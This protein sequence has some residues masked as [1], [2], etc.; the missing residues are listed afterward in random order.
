MYK[1]QLRV[2][3]SAIFLLLINLLTVHYIIPTRDQQQW[4][5]GLYKRST[6]NTHLSTDG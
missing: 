2:Q 4:L 5:D 1:Q 3:W 6:R